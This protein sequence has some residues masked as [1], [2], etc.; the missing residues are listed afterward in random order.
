MNFEEFFTALKGENQELAGKLDKLR[1]DFELEKLYLICINE[2][3]V[4]WGVR[5]VDA[6]YEKV[7]AKLLDFIQE[8]TGLNYDTEMTRLVVFG[9]EMAEVDYVLNKE[10]IPYIESHEGKLEILSINENTGEI[11]VSL[12]GTCGTCPS[13]I[14]TMKAG[15]ERTL[16]NLLPWVKKVRSADEP[17]DPEF[18]I[19]QVLEETDKEQGGGNG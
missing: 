9:N 14:F 19:Q 11:V 8:N 2:T 17:K 10:L 18:G 15:V 7:A 6:D 3:E 5:A 4:V 13:A 1:Q 16:K 12:S